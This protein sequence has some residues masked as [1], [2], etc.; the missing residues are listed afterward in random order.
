MVPWRRNLYILFGSF[1][2]VM[3]VYLPQ[4]FV[5]DIW[6]LVVLQALTGLADG[7]ILPALGAL[8][9][10]R[11]PAGF[12]GVTYGLNA[13]VNSAGRCVAPMLGAG[14]AIWLGLRSVFGLAAVIYAAASL[15]AL[16]IKR[17]ES[18]TGMAESF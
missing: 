10:L 18:R 1:I 5:T 16:H 11:I 2:A 12:Q 14:F 3:L 6:Q 8:L 17:S 4:P 7:G 15:L 13:S 9:N